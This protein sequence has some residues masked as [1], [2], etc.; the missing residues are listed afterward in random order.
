MVINVFIVTI[1]YWLTNSNKIIASKNHLITKC[2][3]NAEAVKYVLMT[4]RLMYL[5]LNIPQPHIIE[6]IKLNYCWNIWYIYCLAIPISLHKL[7][8]LRHYKSQVSFEP[9][10]R[11]I[12]CN[13]KH[14]WYVSFIFL[15]FPTSLVMI[16][17]D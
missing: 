7:V 11:W 14:V 16:N 12:K 17:I 15:M 9:C 10:S 1:E 4:W 2:W 8:L 5:K 3:I 6:A 13:E